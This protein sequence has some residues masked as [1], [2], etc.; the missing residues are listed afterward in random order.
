VQDTPVSGLERSTWIR[1]AIVS[2]LGFL[3]ITL[4]WFEPARDWPYRRAI[5]QAFHHVLGG[6]LGLG[7]PSAWVAR[8]WFFVLLPVAVLRLAGK[9]PTAL[10]L[11]SH[12]MPAWRIVSVSFAVSLPAL[13]WLGLRPGIQGYY[14]ELFAPDGWKMIVAIFL[15]IVA[16]HVWIAGVML[17]LALPGGGLPPVVAE[18][19]RRGV[20]GSLGFG[21]P[22]GARGLSAWLGVP[23]EAWPALLGQALVFGAIH[24]QKDAGEIVTSLP[25]GL[26]LGILTYRVRSIWP[27]VVLHAGTSAVILA[28]AY[29]AYTLR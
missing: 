12:E 14:R 23:E 2:G 26:A 6:T 8:C 15:Q 17:A 7:R 21:V 16:E 29:A 1:A 22:P 19:P 9:R 27:T 11:G 10:G 25:G 24:A 18:P 5:D 4:F 13:V 28:I 20:L 3:W